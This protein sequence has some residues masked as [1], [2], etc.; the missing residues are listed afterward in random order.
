MKNYTKLIQTDTL[1]GYIKYKSDLKTAIIIE[2]AL[3]SN[4][5]N[6]CNE[7]FIKGVFYSQN[8]VIESN[9]NVWN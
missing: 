4:D 6:F 2:Y 9:A 1:M 5:E 7:S 3:E 8:V